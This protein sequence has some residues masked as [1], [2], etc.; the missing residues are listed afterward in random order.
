MKA[1]V[2]LL[3]LLTFTNAFASEYGGKWADHSVRE[4]SLEYVEETKERFAK[5][6]LRLSEIIDFPAQLT[7]RDLTPELQKDYDKFLDDRLSSSKQDKLIFA[8]LCSLEEVRTKLETA[9]K[10]AFSEWEKLHSEEQKQKAAMTAADIFGMEIQSSNLGVVLDTSPS[11]KPYV[12]AVR[13]EIMKSFPDAHFREAEGSGL[14]QSYGTPVTIEGQS[15]QFRQPI[16]DAWF[17]GR[18]PTTGVNPFDPKWHEPIIYKTLPHYR[19]IELERNEM[20]ALMALVTLHEVDTLYWFCDCEDDIEND[21][22]RLL[23]KA[24]SE[25]NVKLYVHS[26]NRRPDKNLLKLIELTKGEVIRKRIR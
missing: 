12:A 9:E 24:M 5:R 10:R 3:P 1:L 13:A 2:F 17:H 22:I 7:Y 4:Y 18:M 15:P 25:N 19:Q 14:S 11:M 23:Y 26:S 6:A 20:A 8:I 16:N 21:A